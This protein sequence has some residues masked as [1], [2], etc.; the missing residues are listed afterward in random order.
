MIR[1]EDIEK[2]DRYINGLVD[3]SEKKY[4]ESLFLNGEKNLYLRNSLN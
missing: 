3:E 2:I 4:L 1:N